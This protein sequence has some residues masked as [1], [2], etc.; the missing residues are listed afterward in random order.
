LK[1]L[2]LAAI[3]KHEVLSCYEHNGACALLIRDP[4]NHEQRNVS[5]DL[6]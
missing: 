6:K 2:I 4:G 5:Y 1:F 3:L